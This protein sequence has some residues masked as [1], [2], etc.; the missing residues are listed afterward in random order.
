MA[1]QRR[2]ER[3]GIVLAVDGGSDLWERRIEACDALA[4]LEECA[5]RDGREKDAFGHVASRLR[6]IRGTSP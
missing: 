2:F 6:A 1:G 4:Y 5:A 3:D